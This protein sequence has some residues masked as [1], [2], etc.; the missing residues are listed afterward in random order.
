MICTELQVSSECGIEI[1]P[2]GTFG[3]IVL[4]RLTHQHR[5]TTL[6]PA[7]I[8][9]RIT[10]QY[11]K[12][13]SLIALKYSVLSYHYLQSAHGIAIVPFFCVTAG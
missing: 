3:R 10:C 2:L 9:W 1:A 8:N 13:H 5:R 4:M 12:L 11:G 6:D 7:L